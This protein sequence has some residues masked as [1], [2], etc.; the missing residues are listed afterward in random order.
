[1]IHSKAWMRRNLKILE[2]I[3]VL[4]ATVLA[5]VTAPARTTSIVLVILLVPE[6]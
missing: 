1:M 4:K 6:T 3:M 5:V 2:Q